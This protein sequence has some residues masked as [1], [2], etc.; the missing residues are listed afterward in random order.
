ME[1]VM[2]A[3]GF[4]FISEHYNIVEERDDTFARNLP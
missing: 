4:F 2:H 1:Y 3:G